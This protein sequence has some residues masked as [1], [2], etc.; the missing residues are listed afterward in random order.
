[1]SFNDREGDFCREYRLS[2]A[3]S[4]EQTVACS[5]NGKWETRVSHRI[6]AAVSQTYQTGSSASS[7][8]IEQWFDE[9]MVDI[10]FSTQME[11]KSL[12]K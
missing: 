4:A 2:Q 12:A 1:M 7:A 10:P 6:Q 9:N 5:I 3:T 11:R 8:E